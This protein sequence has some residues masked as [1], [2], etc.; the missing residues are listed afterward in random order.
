MRSAGPEPILSLRDAHLVGSWLPLAILSQ[1]TA[2]ER[3]LY[4]AGRKP[5]KQDLCQP[6]VTSKPAKWRC[7]GRNSFKRVSR[8]SSKSN[9][10]HLNLGFTLFNFCC[11]VLNA[12]V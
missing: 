7:V 11:F 1:S 8:A 12:T 9:V 10:L 6:Y 4:P 2:G 3:R 5:T